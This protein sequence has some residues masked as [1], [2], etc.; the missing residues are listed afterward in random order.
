MVTLNSKGIKLARQIFTRARK[1]VHCTYHIF[2]ASGI[3]CIVILAHMEYYCAKESVVAGKI[4]ELGFKTFS[5]DVGYV[6]EYMKFLLLVNDDI[7]NLFHL[8]KMLD[9]YLRGQ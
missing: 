3:S 7:S 5:K 8:F 4:F 2:V 1:N 9:P 6:L